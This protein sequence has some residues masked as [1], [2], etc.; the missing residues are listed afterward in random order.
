MLMQH[1]CTQALGR[2]DATAL[3]NSHAHALC[4]PCEQCACMLAHLRTSTRAESTARKMEERQVQGSEVLR[5]LCSC[6]M[7]R[8][9]DEPPAQRELSPYV[10]WRIWRHMQQP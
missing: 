10:L 4:P 9:Q 2:G 6:A 8:S 7:R 5:E 1:L 3:T